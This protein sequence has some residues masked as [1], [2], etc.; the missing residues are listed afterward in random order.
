MGQPSAS[1]F[2]S[3]LRHARKDLKLSQNALADALG[4]SR[5]IVQEWEKGDKSPSMDRLD[6]IAEALGQSV[7][8]FF[9]ETEE[10]LDVAEVQASVP[11]APMDSGIST[12]GV[13]PAALAALIS[14]AVTQ[15]VT[16]AVAHVQAAS[17]ERLTQAVTQAT[18]PLH[19]KLDAQA[20]KLDAQAHKLNHQAAEVHRLRQEVR[21][22]HR[23]QNRL[24]D[25]KYHA[26]HNRSDQAPSA[27]ARAEGA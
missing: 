21:E 19:S 6:S 7:P 22:Q 27:D 8:W 13:D 9:E 11:R 14:Q 4:V 12:N 17:E 10:V 24:N 5:T 18:A 23:S 15:A 25:A 20:H 3:R 26:P 1:R 2:A 16:Q